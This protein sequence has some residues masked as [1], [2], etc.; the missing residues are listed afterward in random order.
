MNKHDLPPKLRTD[1]NRFLEAHLSLA[2]PKKRAVQEPAIRR[3]VAE[4]MEAFGTKV[5]AVH[6]VDSPAHV[7]ELA[8]YL[9]EPHGQ[10]RRRGTAPR[11]DRRLRKLAQSEIDQHSSNRLYGR[12][13]LFI[14]GQLRNSLPPATLLHFFSL[15]A[16]AHAMR[17]PD[18]Q[19]LREISL[20]QP[21][22]RRSPVRLPH[23]LRPMPLPERANRLADLLADTFILEHL[24]SEKAAAG[25]AFLQLNR[26]VSFA[27]FE[28]AIAVVCRYP[29]KIDYNQP[30]FKGLFPHIMPIRVYLRYH[31]GSSV[32][33][34]LQSPLS[35]KEQNAVE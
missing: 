30:S 28:S 7:S 8:T 2:R 18:P 35:G 6:V 34:S 23:P 25:R 14:Q 13:R 32:E 5:D 26:C 3:T 27:L 15:R 1:L 31:D 33:Y 17:N 29:K 20:L 11:F 4:L 12:I 9:W 21:V 10:Y 19:N 22:Q 16:L 24:R